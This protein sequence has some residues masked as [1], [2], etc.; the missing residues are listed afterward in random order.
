MDLPTQKA[1]INSKGATNPGLSQEVAKTG[2]Q[3]G[4]TAFELS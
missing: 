3:N 2:P 4:T 1:T